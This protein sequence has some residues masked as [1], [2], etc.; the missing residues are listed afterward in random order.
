MG[1]ETSNENG[2]SQATLAEICSRLVNG[3]TNGIESEVLL[4]FD[5]YSRKSAQVAEIDRK[6]KIVTCGN[7]EHIDAFNFVRHPVVTAIA[8]HHRLYFFS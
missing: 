2:E 1:Y 3:T 6:G 4:E 8:R 7:F 5:T